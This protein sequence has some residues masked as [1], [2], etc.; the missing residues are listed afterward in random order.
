MGSSP[1]KIMKVI[2]LASAMK[3]SSKLTDPMA[4]LCSRL[5]VARAAV[6]TGSRSPPP[7]SS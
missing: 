2:V 4:L 6:A 3:N 5:F 1:K 7:K